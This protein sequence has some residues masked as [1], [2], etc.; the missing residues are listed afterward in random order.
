MFARPKLHSKSE[1]LII[2]VVDGQNWHDRADQSN[3]C[4]QTNRAGLGNFIK[5]QI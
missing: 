3:R 5:M 1:F 2:S 4:A